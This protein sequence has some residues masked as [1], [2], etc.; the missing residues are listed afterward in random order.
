MKHHVRQQREHHRA[1]RA[2]LGRRRESG[3]SDAS[4]IPYFAPV[5]VTERPTRSTPARFSSFMALTTV[6]YFTV[7]SALMTTG[8]WASPSWA[9]FHGTIQSGR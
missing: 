9:A 8:R 6:S 1:R 4:D 2:A 7:L 3:R 5:V